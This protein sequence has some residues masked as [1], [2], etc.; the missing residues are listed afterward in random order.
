[1]FT[2]SQILRFAV[3]V[4]LLGIVAQA[5]PVL[6]DSKNA[7]QKQG[8]VIQVSDN[9]PATW[10]TALN[11]AKQIPIEMGKDSIDIE[12]V[13]FGPGINMLKFDS[14]LGNRL[15]EARKNGV[16]IIACGT[17]MKALKLSEKDL[18]PSA[19]VIKAGAVEMI[20]KHQAG[21]TI[22]RP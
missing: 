15:A 1:M 16:D 7:T 17:A 18:H 9:N 21:W 3:A 5:T 22:I 19:R 20:Q 2:N 12:I 6:A 11:V 4:L 14:E 10:N 8:L 13:A